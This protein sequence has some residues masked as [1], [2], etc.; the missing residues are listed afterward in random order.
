MCEISI[1]VP[2][3][4]AEKY[5]NKCVDSILNQT[6]KDFELILVDDGSHDN[7]GAICD[8]YVEKDLRVKVVHQKNGGVSRVRNKGI[9]I[10][11]G[12]YIGFVDSD[13]FIAE[14][15]YELLYNNLLKEK[16][17]LSICGIYDVYKGKKLEKNSPNYLITNREEAVK[18]I[19]EA[20]IVSVHPVNKLYKKRL[21]EGVIYPDGS[22][23]EDAAVMF[24]LLENADVIVIDTTQKYYYYHRENSITTK[25][26]SSLDLKTIEV[27]QDNE[28]YIKEKYPQYY[29]IAHTRV[30]WANLIVLDKLLMSDSNYLTERKKIICFLRNNFSFIMKNDY[31]TRNRKISMMLLQINVNL[32]KIASHY[33]YSKNKTRNS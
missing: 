21:F 8:E 13:D 1:I 33:E 29:S 20:K 15:M 10:A 28:I 27:W 11:K 14:D 6:F 23:T 18:L 22:I 9:E 25:P 5:L 12:K 30:C 26:F 4:N 32:Y 19:L 2:V 16:A 31:F 24:H 7:S 17:D 3:Y